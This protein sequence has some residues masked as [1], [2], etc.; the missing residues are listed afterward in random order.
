MAFHLKTDGTGIP[1]RPHGGKEFTLGELQQLVGGYIE[2]LRLST[3]LL[4]VMNEDGLRLGL[5]L[6][7]AASDIA[8]Q[9]VLGKVVLCNDLEAGYGSEWIDAEVGCSANQSAMENDPEA[10]WGE[11]EE[12]KEFLRKCGIEGGV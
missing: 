3:G 12:D 2:M 11:S 7:V 4:M 6:N 10:H 5:P 8:K 1:I 9:A